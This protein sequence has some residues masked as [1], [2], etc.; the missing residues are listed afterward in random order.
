MFEL[1]GGNVFDRYIIVNSGFL[2]LII[3]GDEVMVDRGFIIRDYLLE[4][5]VKLV[6]L[7]FIYKCKWGK[8]KRLN[9]GE[10]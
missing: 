4:R 2:D 1:W 9:F 6:I 7:L 5:R 10:I 8:G 3:V